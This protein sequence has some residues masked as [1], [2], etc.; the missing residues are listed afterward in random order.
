MHKAAAQDVVLDAVIN[1]V[2]Y[3]DTD[4]VSQFEENPTLEFTETD[5]GQLVGRLQGYEFQIIVQP[6]TSAG[7][8][9]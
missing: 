3:G 7:S 2:V 4:C 5:K 9:H 8:G 1:M 6:V